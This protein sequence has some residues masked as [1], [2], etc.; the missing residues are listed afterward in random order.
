MAP[1]HEITVLPANVNP[2]ATRLPR[3]ASER[4]RPTSTPEISTLSPMLMPPVSA[5][6]A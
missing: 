6:S 5:N 2:I 1:L 3:I 4:T